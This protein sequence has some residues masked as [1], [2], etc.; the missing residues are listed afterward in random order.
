KL[1]RA[2]P[3]QSRATRSA[4]AACGFRQTAADARFR[5]VQLRCGR[6]RYGPLQYALIAA[7][8]LPG[9]PPSLRG[10]CTA[11]CAGFKRRG[12]RRVCAIGKFLH[13]LAEGFA[14]RFIITEL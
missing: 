1:T 6:F 10:P 5:D 12:G 2:T 13:Q 4:I 11:P 14:A 9:A 7:D 8:P 3:G